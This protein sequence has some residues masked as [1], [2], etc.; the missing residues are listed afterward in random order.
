MKCK[1][2]GLQKKT[3][4]GLKMHIKLLHLRTGK[5][6]CRRCQFSAN[7]MNSINTHYKIKHPEC[8][9]ENPDFEERSDEKLNFS[10]EFWKESWDIPT[11]AERKALVKAKN[12]DEN[13]INPKKRKGPQGRPK[14][15]KKA[16]KKG[17][18]R[19]L[20]ESL[21][22]EEIPAVPNEEILSQEVPKPMQAVETGTHCLKITQNVAFEFFNFG[23]FHQFL[24][25]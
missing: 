23:I 22:I 1:E 24:S 20:S 4:K 25:T 3:I 8:E 10:H 5:F 13:P 6:L 12:N 16:K 19:K 11:L 18:K 15:N 21:E 9:P 17:V 2:C 7:M 14:G